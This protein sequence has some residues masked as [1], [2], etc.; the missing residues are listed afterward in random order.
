MTTEAVVVD[1]DPLGDYEVGSFFFASPRG[2]VLAKGPFTAPEHGSP[3]TVGALPFDPSA[4]ALLSA[5]M[6][7]RRTGRL[8]LDTNDYS[9][10]AARF[11]ITPEP[12]PAEFERG[13]ASALE[14]MEAGEF[15]KVVLARTLRLDSPVDVDVRRM[16]RRLAQRDPRGY[17]FAV[18]L[19]SVSGQRTLIGASP[20]LLVSK[21]GKQV[22]SNPLAGSRPRSA[23][24]EEDRR[25]VTD[26]LS[27]KKDRR[28]HAVVVEAVAEALRPY[29][30]KLDVPA[31]P[32]L[33]S[34]ATMWHLSTRVTGEL[35]DPDVSSVELARALHPTPA[36]C[37][38]PT[39]VARAAIGEIE[40]FDRGF[41]TG[42]L[43]WSDDSGD[44]EWIVTI[45]CAEVERRSVRLFAGAGIVPGS[46]PAAELAET[47]AKFRTL[48]LALGIE[49]DA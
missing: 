32:A 30:V 16:L 21:C 47:S 41:Y 17:T 43:G 49:Q 11:G 8:P 46:D 7:V 34:T 25:R 26:L 29:C 10:S 23:D 20:E 9:D 12:A 1:A 36:V 48:L 37:G 39:A 14:R 5:P 24:V 3:V 31:G 13:V 28:E 33:V 35:A 38:Q 40:P 4:P 27:S 18:D 19:P 2:T 15:A 6:T 45:R 22:L 44:G 42:A